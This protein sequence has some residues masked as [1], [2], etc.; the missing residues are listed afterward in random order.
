MKLQTTN[1][2]ILFALLAI[3]PTTL[4]MAAQER[5]EGGHNRG[6]LAAY[7][8]VFQN[9]NVTSR[10]LAVSTAELIGRRANFASV[11]NKLAKEAWS[12]SGLPTPSYG[13]LPSKA[14]LRTFGKALKVNRVMY[15]SVSWH[16]RSIWVNVGPKTIST[17]TASV[18]VYDVNS[19]KVVYRKLNVQGRSDE[20]TNGWK[21]AGDVLLTPLVTG[22]SGGPATPR[23]QRAVEIALRRA[24]YGWVRPQVVSSNN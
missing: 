13:H 2:K 20:K 5:S 9:G 15:G 1:S 6:S 19:N 4:A 17:A 22:V 14:S 3:V 12:N 18:Y 8:W 10:T 16:T 21:I 23:E 24:Y 7:P 11:S